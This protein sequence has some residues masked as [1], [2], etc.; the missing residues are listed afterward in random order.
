MENNI[1]N[2]RFGV[3]MVL[4][5]VTCVLGAAGGWGVVGWL[6]EG[7]CEREGGNG[8]LYRCGRLVWENGG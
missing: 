8:C 3:E 1:Q 6:R 7:G 4:R 2:G 5:P